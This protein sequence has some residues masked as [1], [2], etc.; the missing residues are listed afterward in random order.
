VRSAR[1]SDGDRVALRSVSR[2]VTDRHDADRA[3][4]RRR[5]AA[6]ASGADGDS[7]CGGRTSGRFT[8]RR[9]YP[10]PR[11]TRNPWPPH[12]S[13]P[14]ATSIF[15][16]PPARGRPPADALPPLYPP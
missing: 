11:L 16:R 15:H 3:R 8:G 7:R 9:A 14:C 12:R 4:H 1:P 5:S 2:I 13:T 6:D 10:R